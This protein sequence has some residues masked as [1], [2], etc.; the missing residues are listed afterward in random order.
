MVVES[1]LFGIIVGLAA[2]FSPG[3]L[4]ALVVTETLKKA[5]KEGFE[6]AISPL[7]SELPIVLFV[8]VILSSLAGN[9]II[10]GAISMLG[11]C[12]LVY[13]GLS[14]LT[15]NAKE[16]REGLRIGNALLRGITTNL[17]NPNAYMFWLT[18]GGPRIIES[19]KIHVSAT[20]LFMLGFYMM[21]VG[22]KTAIAIVVDKF[23]TLVGRKY[24]V[25]I[26]RALG[27][28]LIAFALVFVRDALEYVGIL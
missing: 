6:V 3:P 23:R 9:R 4:T 15:V 19:A 18:V 10:I 22:S 2:G 5:K 7:I 26:I 17:L 16:S 13:L 25:Y 14:N 20:I 21:L 12:F 28:V 24:Y 8:L 1:L 27:I 11:A